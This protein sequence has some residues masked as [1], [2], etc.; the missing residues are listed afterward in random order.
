M[1]DEGR[2]AHKLLKGSIWRSEG[3]GAV[4]AVGG[5]GTVGAVGG[6]NDEGRGTNDEGQMTRDK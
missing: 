2:V 5:V 4:G 6:T 3:V 1:N